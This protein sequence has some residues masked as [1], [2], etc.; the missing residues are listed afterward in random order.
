M[1]AEGIGTWIFNMEEGAKV[2][3]AIGHNIKVFYT[4][5]VPLL[6]SQIQRLHPQ[7]RCK[8]WGSKINNLETNMLI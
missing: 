4:E 7:T 3:V 6:K 1:Q 8:L 5:V 2:L